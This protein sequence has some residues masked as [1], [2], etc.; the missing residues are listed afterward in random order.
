MPILRKVVKL[1]ELLDQLI[2]SCDFLNKETAISLDGQDTKDVDSADSLK[3]TDKVGD[4]DVGGENLSGEIETE[5][6]KSIHNINIH[7]RRGVVN[8]VS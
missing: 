6:F 8:F 4:C 3:E 2:S 1:V 7:P 5:Q